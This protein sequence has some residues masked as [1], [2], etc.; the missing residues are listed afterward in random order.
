MPDSDFVKEY[1]VLTVEMFDDFY[2]FLMRTIKDQTRVESTGLKSVA[3]IIFYH[4]SALFVE[5][6]RN[7]KLTLDEHFDRLRTD[8]TALIGMMKIS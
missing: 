6:V 7:E 8:L 4:W 3:E 5:I 2:V 1:D